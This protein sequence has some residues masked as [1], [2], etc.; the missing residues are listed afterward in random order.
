MCVQT[1]IFPNIW[2]QIKLIRTV[3]IHLKSRV[4]VA[5]HK[6]G[7]TARKWLTHHLQLGLCNNIYQHIFAFSTI[8]DD[9]VSECEWRENQTTNSA[10]VQSDGLKA[11]KSGKI[12]IF[13]SA[14]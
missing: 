2:Y 5:R 7:C 13:I 9:Y 12:I 4:A 1:S 14:P 11:T 8:F 6:S 3:F 10:T